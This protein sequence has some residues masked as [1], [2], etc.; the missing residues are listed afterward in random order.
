MQ[1]NN[2]NTTEKQG[3]L[4][5]VI[6]AETIRELIEAK[7]VSKDKKLKL[8][9]KKE[10]YNLINIWKANLQEK[11]D[12]LEETVCYRTAD[13]KFAN[14][15]NIVAKEEGFISSGVQRIEYE[16]GGDVYYCNITVK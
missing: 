12:Y 3:E 6:S 1:S 15:F 5:E 13:E 9:V 4:Y 14:M 10:F 7:K 16:Q 8:K 11:E 2:M